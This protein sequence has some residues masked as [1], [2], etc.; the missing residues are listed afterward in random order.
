MTDSDH[1]E[2]I[3]T[4]YARAVQHDSAG[5]LRRNIDHSKIRSSGFVYCGESAPSTFNPQLADNDITSDA[6]GPQIYNTLL[7]IDPE[8]H[9]PVASLASSWTV[10]STGLEY[11]FKLR[12]DVAFQTT[13]WFSPTRPLNAD[14]V[15]FSFRRIIDPTNPYHKVGQTQ[16]PWFKGIDFQNLLV[17]VSALDDL[18]VKFVLSRPDNSFLSNIATSHAVIL[19]LEYANQLI[20][21]DEKRSWITFHWVLGLFTLPNT[22]RAI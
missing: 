19:S 13:P 7:T 21:D 18:T 20:I 14:D 1:Y 4:I 2:C 6:L 15:V 9:L 16:Y 3:I 5:R 22:I 8:T 17:D 11:V 10:N 12:P